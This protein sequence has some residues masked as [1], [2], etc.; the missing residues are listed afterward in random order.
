[1]SIQ[2]VQVKEDF[3][4]AEAAVMVGLPGHPPQAGAGA[5]FLV[6]AVDLL[7]LDNIPTPRHLAAALEAGVDALVRQHRR[8]RSPCN[9][10]AV[11][12]GAPPLPV[13]VVV[14]V[15][16]A[17]HDAARLQLGDVSFRVVSLLPLPS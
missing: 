10:G 5:A 14:A 17:K 11:A 6:R 2:I 9:S 13:A 7:V 12:E 4:G 16:P 15:Q 3:L 1:M 8:L